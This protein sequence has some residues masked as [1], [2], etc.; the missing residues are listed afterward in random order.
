MVLGCQSTLAIAKRFHVNS[1]EAWWRSDHNAIAA[2]EQIGRRWL[3]G[4]LRAMSKEVPVLFHGTRYARQMLAEDRL[5]YA[6]SGYEAVSFT[7]S[8]EVATHWAFLYA[9]LEHERVGAVLVFDR[10]KLRARF[11]LEPFHDPIWDYGVSI[12]DEAEERVWQRDIT[13][14]SKFLIGVV[15]TDGL[16]AVPDG[17][18]TAVRA[19]QSMAA[20]RARREAAQAAS[21]TRKKQGVM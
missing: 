5:R 2:D 10:D 8:A 12:N 7:R 14:L 16:V 18:P 19:A 1:S 15:W 13:P 4:I 21:R 20:A 3:P 6:L 9:G 11:R 17:R